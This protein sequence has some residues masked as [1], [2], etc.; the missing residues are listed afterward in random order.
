M[1]EKEEKVEPEED[2]ELLAEVLRARRSR[3]RRR[4]AKKVE[5]ER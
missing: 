1:A 4:T 5:A 3:E 2:A